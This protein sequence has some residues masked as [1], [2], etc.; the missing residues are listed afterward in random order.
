MNLIMFHRR[1]QPPSIP[2]LLFPLRLWSRDLQHF[3]A[4]AF[5]YLPSLAP[6][7][8][9]W[10]T[11]HF[12]VWWKANTWVSEKSGQTRDMK[13]TKAVMEG[14]RGW[15]G[16]MWVVEGESGQKLFRERRTWERE[17]G[18][19]RAVPAYIARIITAS[20]WLCVNYGRLKLTEGSAVY[21][22]IS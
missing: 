13:G 18:W 2:P 14:Q 15:A 11:S 1:G 21:L 12:T 8:V 3:Q 17:W 6:F 9:F 22:F 7:E 5:W 20:Y 16:G 19:E 4:N 10:I